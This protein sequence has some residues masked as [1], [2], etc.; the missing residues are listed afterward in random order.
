MSP[1]DFG[2]FLRAENTRWVKVV[3]EAGIKPQ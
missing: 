1:A 3:K 2:N